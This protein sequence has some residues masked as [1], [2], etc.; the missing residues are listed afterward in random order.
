MK[1]LILLLIG[2]GSWSAMAQPLATTFDHAQELGYDISK[3]DSMYLSAV[4]AN[5]EL[6]VFDDNQDEFII[7]YKQLHQD[8]H[9]FLQKNDFKWKK[10]I[11]L[12]TRVYFDKDGSV[13]FFLLNPKKTN[14]SD[15]ESD[16]LF[17]LIN[18]FISD[19][20]IPLTADTPFAQCSPVTYM[21]TS[22]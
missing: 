15:K 11:K 5:P 4:H 1:S 19:Y 9:Y 6:A 2:F 8:L 14:L 22:E 10:Q 16:R 18:E 17:S 20:Q 13:D 3:L 12:F 7:S 21:P